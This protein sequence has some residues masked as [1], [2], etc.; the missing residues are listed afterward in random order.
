MP[1][2][3]QAQY[4]DKKALADRGLGRKEM[5]MTG[6]VRAV[7]PTGRPPAGPAG[8]PAQAAAPA[9]PQGP[10]PEEHDLMVRY[11]ESASALRDAQALAGQPGAGAWTQFLVQ[12]AQQQNNDAAMALNHGTPNWLIEG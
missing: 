1:Q 12:L 2:H 7:R 6:A 4:G 8:L 11:A 5:P 3:N 10:A 9:S